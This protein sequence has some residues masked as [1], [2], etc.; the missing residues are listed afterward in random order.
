MLAVD[1][2]TL[3]FSTA[4]P[5]PRTIRWPA[6]TGAHSVRLSAVPDSGGAIEASGTWALHRLFRHARLSA[7]DRPEAMRA[8]FTVGGHPAEFDVVAQSVENPLQL[9]ALEQFRCPPKS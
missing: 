8:T 3:N 6:S 5:G 2:Q 7:T 9:P 4:S 1:G